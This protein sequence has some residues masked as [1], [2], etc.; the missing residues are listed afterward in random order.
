MEPGRRGASPRGMH[1][2]LRV[3]SGDFRAYGRALEGAGEDGGRQINC[4]VLS[5]SVDLQFR[6]SARLYTVMRKTEKWIAVMRWKQK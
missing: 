5:N 6:I 4:I 3:S 1:Y 2:K